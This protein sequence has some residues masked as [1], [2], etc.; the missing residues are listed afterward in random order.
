[1]NIKEPRGQLDT[2]IVQTRQNH[3]R[4]TALT[5]T[6]AHILIA[7]SAVTLNVSVSQLSN[8]DI[9]WA[10]LILAIQAVITIFFASL[11][12]MPKL[13][14]IKAAKTETEKLISIFC[15][16]FAHLDYPSFNRLMEKAMNDPNEVYEIQIRE[17][18]DSGMVIVH[19]KFKYIRYSFISFLSGLGL[20][21]I[22]LLISVL[23]K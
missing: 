22:V 1:M 18:Y 5:D 8:P 4:L 11:S 7:I 10:A 6:K 3:F 19:K 15:T 13:Y 16:N 12:I 21:V 9:K 23:T 17:I 2:M 20:A 14:N